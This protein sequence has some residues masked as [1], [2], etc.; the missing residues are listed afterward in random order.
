M[1]LL[2]MKKKGRSRT[3]KDGLPVGMSSAALDR[4]VSKRSFNA[5]R[6]RAPTRAFRCFAR[7]G[8]RPSSYLNLAVACHIVPVEVSECLTS[9]FV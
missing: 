7:L 9:T 4:L 3:V 8:S 6:A 2:I 1:I 5:P